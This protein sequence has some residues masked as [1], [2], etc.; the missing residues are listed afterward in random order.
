MQTAA[1]EYS[2]DEAEG[3]LAG[4]PSLFMSWTEPSLLGNSSSL[5]LS[6]GQGLHLTQSSPTSSITVL[7]LETMRC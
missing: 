5:R 2:W 3:K 6:A 4:G 1:A 7:K